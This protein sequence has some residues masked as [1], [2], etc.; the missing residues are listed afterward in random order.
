MCVRLPCINEEHCE[1]VDHEERS[2]GGRQKFCGSLL[3]RYSPARVQ[4][5]V[6]QPSLQAADVTH[7]G[8]WIKVLR[9][10]EAG[11]TP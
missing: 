7:E 4:A 3:Q 1:S 9:G 5:V 8:G 10:P 2:E 11:Q 6:G